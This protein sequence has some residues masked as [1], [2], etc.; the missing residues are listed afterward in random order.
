MRVVLYV[1]GFVLSAALGCQTETECIE[2]PVQ[3]EQ[4]EA[5]MCTPAP[6]SARSEGEITSATARVLADGTLIL[7][8]SSMG[9]RCEHTDDFSILMGECSPRGW[10]L[11]AQISA[12]LVVP[13]IIDLK[14]RVRVRDLSDPE[15]GMSVAEFNGEFE[16]VGVT[17]GC[18]TGV[19]HG[20]ELRNSQVSGPPRLDG[21]F[22]APRC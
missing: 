2:G 4:V 8:W 17:D 10:L 13:G 6:D 18:V 1:V 11:E 12:E 19:F 15:E 20:F 5:S 16:L 21:S 9:L 7:D 14:R 22:L 3:E